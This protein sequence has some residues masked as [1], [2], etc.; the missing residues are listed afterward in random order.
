MQI[1]AE[2]NQIKAFTKQVSLRERTVERTRSMFS[3]SVATEANLDDAELSLS[4][5]AN[6]LAQAKAR[7][8]QT[9]VRFVLDLVVSTR[10]K[11][12]PYKYQRVLMME[13]ASALQVKVKQVSEVGVQAIYISS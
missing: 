4:V 5:T 1:A 9:H 13:R 7:L 3:R 2:Q 6:Q 12:Y 8:S 10:K 11:A